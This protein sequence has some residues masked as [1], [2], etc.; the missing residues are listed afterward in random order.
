LTGLL[1]THTLLWSIYSPS[2]LSRKA[3][4]LIQNPR[5]IF[6]V[7]A[8]SAWE[9]ATKVRRG[10]MPEADR[11]EKNFLEAM[12]QAGYTLRS[13][14]VEDGLRAGRLP[15]NHRDPFDRILAA[16]AIADDL[17]VLSSD[18]NLDKLGVRRIWRV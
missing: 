15:G 14:T 17:P 3:A 6:L 4:S 7:S 1:D 5:N 10:K 16:Q 18:E 12:Q 8:A 13:V 9:I 11:L 2:K